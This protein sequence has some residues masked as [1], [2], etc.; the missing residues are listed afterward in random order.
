MEEKKINVPEE[1]N[2]DELDLVAGGA[3]TLEQWKAMTKEERL[4]AQR[5]S[6]DAHAKNLPCELD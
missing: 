1:I 6:L 2:D 5:R 3:Y 4:A